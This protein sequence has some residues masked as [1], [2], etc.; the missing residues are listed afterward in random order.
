MYGA[1]SKLSQVTEHVDG[2]LDLFEQF[3]QELEEAH[4]T[5][6]GMFIDILP[7]ELKSDCMRKSKLQAMNFRELAVWAKQRVANIQTQALAE[8][9]RK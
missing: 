3:G 2:W 4:T 8:N 1:C 7:Q 6:R 9:T 5:T